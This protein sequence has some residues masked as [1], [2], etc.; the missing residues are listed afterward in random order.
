MGVIHQVK[1]VI[2]QV[3]D[4]EAND[5]HYDFIYAEIEVDTLS[6]ECTKSIDHV[7]LFIC[8]SVPNLYSQE[9]KARRRTS[10]RC[11]AVTRTNNISR[12]KKLGGIDLDSC[13]I[14]DEGMINLAVCCSTGTDI[15]I[16]N[17]GFSKLRL[18]H[19]K[20][21][22]LSNTEV[23]SNGLRYS[24]VGRNDG[25]CFLKKSL[26]LYVVYDPVNNVWKSTTPEEVLSIFL[27]DLRVM[28]ELQLKRAVQNI[29]LTIPVS[30]SQFR[31]T[32]IE[33]A[34]VMVG[35]FILRLMPEPTA[36]TGRVSQ[37]KALSGSHIKGEDIVQNIMHHLLPNMGS[38]F[39]SHKNNEMKAMGSLRVAA[40]DAV[41][42]LSLQDIVMIDVDLENG[43]RI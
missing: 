26:A 42:K 32:Q 4:V 15:Y 27:V 39:L 21:L 14:G 1:D 28:A 17:V 3:E 41:I 30:F 31:L 43:L 40:Q 23:G 33:Q 24:L 12:V 35:L 11:E 8:Y 29:V 38:L 10:Q 7:V 18:V 16:F 9:D 37:I 2:Q 6:K 34:C 20:I 13:K 19:L 22:E 5:E 36:T 25:T